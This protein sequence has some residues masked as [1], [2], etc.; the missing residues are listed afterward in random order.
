[1]FGIAKINSNDNC[2]Y[3]LKQK[4]CIVTQVFSMELV[5]GKDLNST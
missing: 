5:C 3:L 2:T 4:S 1:M